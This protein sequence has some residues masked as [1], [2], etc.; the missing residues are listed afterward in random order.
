MSADPHQLLAST[1]VL[2][3][4][5]PFTLA[6]WQTSQLSA[7]LGGVLRSQQK[8]AF[9]IADE[10]EVTAFTATRH[11]D[12]F[13]PPLHREDNWCLLT[14]DTVMDWDVVGVL[15]AV[16]NALA[17]AGIPMGAVTAFSRDHLL[18]SADHIENAQRTLAVLC[19][20]ISV[21]D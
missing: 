2:V 21:I 15:A 13:P 9:V 10:M 16:S 14:L 12:N 1:T 18:V 17:G 7:V 4:R 8:H 6:A 20:G 19:K 5:G 3:R 11:L